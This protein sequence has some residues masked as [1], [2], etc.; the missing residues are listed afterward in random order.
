M[1]SPPPGACCG[2]QSPGHRIVERA[3]SSH[4]P[5][6]QMA[7][8]HPARLVHRQV[9]A[10]G[11]KGG[12]S[13]CSRESE[14]LSGRGPRWQQEGGPDTFQHCPRK[15]CML[16][17]PA[18]L[19]PVTCTPETGVGSTLPWLRVGP[20]PQRDPDP[21]LLIC[22]PH[23]ATPKPT[24]PPRGGQAAT[25][26]RSGGSCSTSLTIFAWKTLEGRDKGGVM[27]RVLRSADPSAQQS[28]L[29]VHDPPT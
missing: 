18:V 26:S 1:P 12:L 7:Q 14:S 9:P 29:V 5:G 22:H 2:P 4:L 19:P 15:M 3:L 11:N 23:S 16:A 8:E 10:E 21:R 24:E 13:H 28:H 6:T 17:S 27:T 25:Y 20:A